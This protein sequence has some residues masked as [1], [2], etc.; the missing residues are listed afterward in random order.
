ME[1]ECQCEAPL[2][3]CDNQG[4]HCIMCGRMERLDLAVG[5]GIKKPPTPMG[6]IEGR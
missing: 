1:L 5:L 3:K 4:C 2:I 6:K